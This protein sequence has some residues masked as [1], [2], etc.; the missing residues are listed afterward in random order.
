MRVDARALTFYILGTH[1][2]LRISSS[3]G[4]QASGVFRAVFSREVRGGKYFATLAM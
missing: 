3:V 1:T 2:R 4:E